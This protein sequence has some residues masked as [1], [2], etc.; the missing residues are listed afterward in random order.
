MSLLTKLEMDQ[1]DEEPE[2]KRELKKE[3]DGV[4]TEILAQLY[5]FLCFQAVFWRCTCT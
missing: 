5:L 3:G 2:G 4:G 1:A